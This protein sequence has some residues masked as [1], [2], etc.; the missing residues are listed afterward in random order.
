MTGFIFPQAAPTPLRG[1]PALRWGV[2]GAG[3]IAGDFIDAMHAHTDQRA[4]AV[5]SRSPEKGARFAAAHGVDRVVE[6]V[7][8]LAMSPDIDV[9]YVATP[10]TAHRAG[11]LAAIAGGKSVLIEKPMATSEAEAQEIADAA[12]EACVFAMEAM[13]TV[14]RPDFAAVSALLDERVLGDVVLADASVAW[15]Q[16]LGADSRMTNPALGGG[17]ILDMGVYA[18]WFAQYATGRAT[19]VSAKGRILPNGVD[20]DAV[21]ALTGASGALATASTSLRTTADG[22]ASISG[23]AGSLRFV[24]NFVFPA[25]FA[26]T[27]AEGAGAGTHEWS[28][29]AMLLGRQGLA[30]EAAGVAALV[31]AG[32]VEAPRHTL[33]DAVALART[34][35]AVRAALSVVAA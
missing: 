13:W 4:V 27:V 33:D 35:D 2:V 14:F 3:G 8:Q 17:A 23:T 22:R 7:E 29:P 31:A 5:A 25:R 19:S 26:V 21:T 28:D 9:V 10:H 24:D 34:S 12:R 20:L 18:Y 32:A 11:A 6:T 16:D 30:Y 15:R 1:M